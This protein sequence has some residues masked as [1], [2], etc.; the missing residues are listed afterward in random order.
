M[1]G[2]GLKRTLIDAGQ[3]ADAD[4]V[5]RP[6]HDTLLVAAACVWV[7]GRRF[8]DADDADGGRR[9]G[10]DGVDG[11]GY[12]AGVFERSAADCFMTISS[13]F[14]AGDQSAAGCEF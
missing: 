4:E 7:H 9:A 10:G 12:A 14:C 8:E 5:Q 3:P 2:S 11:D 6:V 1:E 13:S